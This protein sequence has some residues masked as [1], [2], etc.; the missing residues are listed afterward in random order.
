MNQNKRNILVVRLSA[1]G[2]VAMTIPAI[3]SA[4]F[5][6]PQHHFI[7]VTSSFPSRLFINRP[8][9]V[10]MMVLD[11]GSTHGIMRTCHLLK[12]LSNMKID[13][14]ADLHSVLRTWMIDALFMFM[15]RPVAI[16]NKRR[17]QRWGILHRHTTSTKAFIQRYFDTFAQLGLNVEPSFTSLFPHEQ[18]PLPASISV[19]K[20][21]KWI[22][23]AP[24]ARYRSKTYDLNQMQE[25][26]D[27]LVANVNYHIFLFGSSG[28]ERYILEWL[29]SGRDQITIVAGML[30]LEEELS[31]MAHL[32][33]MLAMDS[34]NMHLASLVGT[35]VIS[36]WCGTTPSC[37]FLGYG[38]LEDDAL[39]TGGLNC[40]PC[41]IAGSEN[42]KQGD[43]LCT[44]AVSPVRIVEKII[45]T[46]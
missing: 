2:D 11:K 17:F 28:R 21:K 33:V 42:C 37:G 25:V 39:L 18:P 40:Q 3:Y 35:R 30:S 7:V 31:L 6:N 36:L 24:F 20:S 22:G 1:L 16:L 15:L 27:M 32:N 12:S 13:A 43:W 10:E 41:T 9:N 29:A 26:I 8:P 34:A 14:V 44:K 38:Q 45:S 46:L 5:S 23:I 19:E 4:A